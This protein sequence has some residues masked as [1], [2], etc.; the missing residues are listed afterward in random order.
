MIFEAAQELLDTT[1]T[2][3]AIEAEK[4]LFSSVVKLNLAN[5]VVILS[6]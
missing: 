6:P 2:L 3:R 4:L 1:R 5:T